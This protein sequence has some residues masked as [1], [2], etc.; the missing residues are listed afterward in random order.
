[1]CAEVAPNT[2]SGPPTT[3][4]GRCELMRRDMFTIDVEDWFH[5]LEVDGTPQQ[6]SWG[7]LPSRVEA[8]FRVLLDMLDDHQ[9]RATCFVLG[10]V[11]ERFPRLV[12][13]AFERGHEIASHGYGHQ[14]IHS[15]TRDE[16]R[17]DISNAKSIIEDITGMEVLGYR[18]PGFSITVRTPWAYEELVAAGFKYDSSIFPG[19]HGHGGIAGYQR[20]CHLIECA[21]GVLAE[22]PISVVDTIAGTKCFF[23]GGYLRLSPLWL[24]ARAARKVRHE[25]RGVMWYIHPREIDPW[26]PRLRMPL[27]RRFKCYVN[28]SQTRQKL[29]AVLR[30]ENFATCREIASGLLSISRISKRQPA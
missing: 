23:G 24:I 4:A 5:I 8:N 1:M 20:R 15:M 7:A 19:V 14:V 29:D 26:H 13:E 9:V 12:R 10:W 28:L 25:N 3:D 27:H 18:A 22:L 2:L 16:F 30:Y 6:S 17:G 21:A 11:A